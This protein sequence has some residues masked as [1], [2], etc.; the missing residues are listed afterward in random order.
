ME[1]LVEKSAYLHIVVDSSCLVS[2]FHKDSLF[3]GSIVNSKYIVHTFM[4]NFE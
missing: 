1:V 4:N 2:L 3:Y